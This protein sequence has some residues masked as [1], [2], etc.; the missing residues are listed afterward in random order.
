MGLE[1]P[2]NINIFNQN[3]NGTGSLPKLKLKK[4]GLRKPELKEQIFIDSYVT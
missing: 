4:L 3:K 1:H 2:I